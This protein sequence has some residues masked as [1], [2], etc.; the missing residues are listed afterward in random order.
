M[1][2]HLTT[3]LTATLALTAQAQA[4]DLRMSW[5][6]GESRHEATQAALKACGETYGH[7]ISPE[8]TGFDGYLEKLTTQMADCSNSVIGMEVTSHGGRAALTL[9]RA[10]RIMFMHVVSAP[11]ARS[12]AV[13]ARG[14]NVPSCLS[15]SR[16][17]V[18]RSRG[19]RFKSSVVNTV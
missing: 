11:S 5:W 1:K 10:D 7:T 2:L 4:A 15:S 6:G 3:A 14:H 18:N 19:L 16:T 12:N 8:F 17:R 13:F 9:C